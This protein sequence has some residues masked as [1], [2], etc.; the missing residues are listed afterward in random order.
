MGFAIRPQEKSVQRVV[1]GKAGFAHRRRWTAVL[2]M[3]LLFAVA[4]G[5][6]KAA[7]PTRTPTPTPTPIPTPTPQQRLSTAADRMEAL[8]SFHFV[9]THED[10][11]SP[12][13]LGLE[14]TRAEGDVQNP[15]RLR[16]TVNAKFQSI[17]VTVK[18]INVG[19]QTWITNPLAGGDQYQPL[20]GG[21]QAA[22]IFD[23]KTG[24]IK[25][26]R[27]AKD[28]QLTGSGTIG[29]VATWIV[30]G[31]ID[32]GD[33]SS[34]ATD[35]QAGH[36]VTAKVWIGKAD[37]LIYQIRLE[38]PL[39]NSEPKNI[40]RQIDTSQFNEQITIQPPS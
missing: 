9:L 19:T 7:A 12:I 8:K 5:A 27:D 38:G 18:V 16:A 26:M 36:Q 15:D 37:S 39:S 32:A 40:V 4:C 21:T 14:M 30:Q 3:I 13:A 22:A 25:A 31:T 20:P 33:L 35:A 2:P 1:N 24:V 17:P 29:N 23:P 6:K 11:A 28:P 10:G 34:I